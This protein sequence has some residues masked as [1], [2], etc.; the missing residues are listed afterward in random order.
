MEKPHP[1]LNYFVCGLMAVGRNSGL[2]W[3]ETCRDFS[4]LA[5]LAYKKESCKVYWQ[6]VQM[7]WLWTLG[8]GSA[9]PVGHNC[10]LIKLAK[11]EIESR[12]W[13]YVS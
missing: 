8:R 1:L 7:I 2:E 9:C 12:D 4:L 11:V 13:R 6:T 10:L 5:S 3:L